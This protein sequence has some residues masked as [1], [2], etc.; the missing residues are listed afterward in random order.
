MSFTSDVLQ[1]NEITDYLVRV[2][3]PRLSAIEGVQR[4]DILGA[5]TFAMRVWL[6]PERLAAF[7]ITPQQV[8][9]A[10]AANNF[11]AAVGETKGSLVQV[12][13]ISNTD[14]STVHEFKRLV[15]REQDGAIVRIEDIGEVALGAEDYDAE[16]RFSGQTATFMGIWPLPNANSIDVIRR[17][18]REMAD[19]RRQLPTGMSAQVAYDATDYITNAIQEVT[20]TLGETLIIVVVIIFLFLGSLRSVLIPV[21]AIPLSLIGAVFLMQVFGFT[22]NLLTLL[23]IVLSVGL[24]VDDAIVVVENVERHLSEG[25]SPMDAALV[26]ARELVSPIIATTIVLAAVYAPIGLQGG[27]T[28]AL[29]REFA[30]TLTGAVIISTVVALTLSPMMASKLLKPG[31]GDRGL[32]GR[33]SR[34]FERFKRMY[35]KLLDATLN[36][37]PAVYLV[38]GIISVLTVPMFMMSPVEL[39]PTEDQGVIF[40][41]LDAAANSTLDQNSP[42]AA[43]VND[44]FMGIPETEY[45]F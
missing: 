26:G 18:T 25:K 39:A 10:L 24:V 36:A 15:I 31:A 29:F 17:V 43:A 19:I 34:D 6:K 40:G 45:T 16:V 37:R 35:G 23:A 44:A 8:R 28:G 32:A 2:V 7:G 27:L 13:L 38:W 22:I 9:Q 30:F 1:Q 12:N 20:K 4:A 3:Q 33:I 21:V 11:L 14:L 5:R 41:I 42:Y